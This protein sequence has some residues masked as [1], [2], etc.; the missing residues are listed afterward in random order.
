[1]ADNPD[2]PQLRF[3]EEACIQCGL[4]RAT[5]P[6]NVIALEP[7]LDFTSAA[8]NLRTIK[9][10]EPFECVRC[11]KPFGT[12]STINTMVEKLKGHSMFS[13][14]AALNRLRMCEDCRIIDMA[15]AGNDPMAEGVR[16]MPRTID[17]YLREREEARRMAREA[18]DLPPEE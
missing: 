4:C 15:E 18:G 2:K 13:D 17:D 3:L 9:E 6:E 10:E 14:E 11:G 12:A 8:R 1:M 16:P 5:C 7:R